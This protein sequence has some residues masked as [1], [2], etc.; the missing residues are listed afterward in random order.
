M[1]R[2]VHTA[3]VPGAQLGTSAE[4]QRLIGGRPAPL[5]PAALPA[6]GA[7]AGR[8]GGRPA[9]PL[10]GLSVEPDQWAAR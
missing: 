10:G 8:G 1:Y 6:S 7:V 2:H 3:A 5:W 9:S 4:W